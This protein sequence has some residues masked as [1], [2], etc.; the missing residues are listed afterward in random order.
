MVALGGASSSACDCAATSRHRC[1]FTR[2]NG[3]D[4]R[5]NEPMELPQ[6]CD[7]AAVAHHHS[8]FRYCRR[9]FWS[10]GFV[11]AKL[12]ATRFTLPR[13][14]RFPCL[15]GYLGISH[16]DHVASQHMGQ[17]RLHTNGFSAAD[18]DRFGHWSLGNQLCCVSVCGYS[19][20]TRQRRGRTL[21]ASRVSD[22]CGVRGFRGAC[23]WRKAITVESFS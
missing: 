23:I 4:P 16:R 15:L 19:C 8:F 12:P 7:R 10:R 17:S 20:G 2:F 5:R 14:V 1:F 22:R 18:P 13:R 6:A 21:A 9:C 11:H 3:V